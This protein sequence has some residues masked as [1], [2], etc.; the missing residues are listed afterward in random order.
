MSY[1]Q[2][3]PLLSPLDKIERH[4][5]LPND[6]Q[7]IAQLREGEDHDD[8]LMILVKRGNNLSILE[9]YTTEWKSGPVYSCDQ[10]DFPL[11]VLSWFPKALEEFIKPPADG[12]LH[13]G[14]MTSGDQ[15]VGGEMLSIGS[16]TKG[17]EITN[18]S[19]DASGVDADP[20]YYE[21][22]SLN[23]DY[24]LLYDYGLLDLWKTLGEKY[25]RGEV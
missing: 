15:E 6:C 23:L 14:A 3:H 9:T 25:E 20:D 16:T 4:D 21:P 18:W 17:Y 22:T 10:Y 8:V 1:V 19:R 11:K 7:I 2:N 5:Q 12:G 24:E 13:A